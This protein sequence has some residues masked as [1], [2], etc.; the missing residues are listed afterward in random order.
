MVESSRLT[1]KNEGKRVICQKKFPR[2]PAV[3]KSFSLASILGSCVSVAQTFDLAS[4][5]PL[6]GFCWGIQNR[7]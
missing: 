4:F 7:I 3:W 1:V 2:A 6:R 5:L